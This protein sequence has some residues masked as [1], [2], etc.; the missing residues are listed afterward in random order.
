MLSVQP[1]SLTTKINFSSSWIVLPPERPSYC[2]AFLS[3]LVAYGMGIDKA[4]RK[5][6]VACIIIR[7]GGG[8]CKL[9]H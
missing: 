4:V 1:V 9:L 2:F 5:L 7:I 8:Y 3:Y 6:E